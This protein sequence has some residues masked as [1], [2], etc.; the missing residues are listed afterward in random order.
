ME[1]KISHIGYIQCPSVGCVGL[2]LF[3]SGH[4]TLILLNFIRKMIVES[5]SQLLEY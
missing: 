4:R 1:Q 3:G 5:H 2:N